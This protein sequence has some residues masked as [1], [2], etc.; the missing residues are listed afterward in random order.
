MKAAR[1]FMPQLMAETETAW[2]APFGPLQPT[3]HL[4]QHDAGI[5]NPYMVLPSNALLH[6]TCWRAQLHNKLAVNNMSTTQAASRHAGQL[7]CN[8]PFD[9]PCSPQPLPHNLPQQ[10]TL[11]CPLLATTPASLA[12]LSHTVL[13]PFHPPCPAATSPSQAG[14][15]TGFEAGGAGFWSCCFSAGLWS[16][17]T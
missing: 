4:H 17:A 5:S 1:R 14:F 16:T 11:Q 12:V 2:T 6:H 13:L 7:N 10:H 9:A 15:Q 3:M 8:K